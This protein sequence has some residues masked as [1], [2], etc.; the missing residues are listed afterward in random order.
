MTLLCTGLPADYEPDPPPVGGDD[1]D[2]V[3]Q[4]STPRLGYNAALDDAAR[5]MR[6]GEHQQRCPLCERWKWPGQQCERGKV[7]H[8]TE[9]V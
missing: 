3:A 1:A 9:E 5:R 8:A 4:C 7:Y 2:Q 6:R